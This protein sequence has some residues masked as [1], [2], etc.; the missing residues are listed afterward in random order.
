MLN[1]VL[2]KTFVSYRYKNR[3]RLT[4]KGNVVTN[5]FKNF[6]EFIYYKN[7]FIYKKG[8]V[9]QDIQR[10]RKFKYDEEGNLCKVIPT[11]VYN[12]LLISFIKSSKRAKDNFYGYAFSNDWKYFITLTVNPNKYGKSD[13]AR[14]RYLANALKLVKYY[15]K[16]A[17]YLG[18][19]ERHHNTKYGGENN[20]TLH[21]HFLANFEIKESLLP[22]VNNKTN[23][24]ITSKTG[25]PIYNFAEKYWKYGFSTVVPIESDKESQEKVVSYL[26]KYMIKNQDF[27]YNARRF[28]RS[29]NLSFKDKKVLF[30]VYSE[31]IDMFDSLF[32]KFIKENE[33]MIIYRIYQENY[34]L[35][36]QDIKD[37]SL[38]SLLFNFGKFKQ[39]N[40]KKSFNLDYSLNKVNLAKK[41]YSEDL[42]YIPSED[43]E[44]LDTIF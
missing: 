18:V 1:Q 10:N 20:E 13:K 15:D 17:K 24:P 21:F 11:A 30:V 5:Q 43:L 22:A 25:R 7:S 9:E 16:E 32:A 2:S 41:K 42:L 4:Y 36:I 14:K 19:W 6:T 23:I 33:K 3:K 40:L 29:R 35:F 27:Q 37:K 12:D 28:Y 31:V 39:K 44:Y 26:C 38:G 8:T 34:E